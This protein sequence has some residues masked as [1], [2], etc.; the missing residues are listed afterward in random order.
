MHDENPT[1]NDL[2]GRAATAAFFGAPLSGSYAT[3]GILT[4]VE[5]LRLDV[6]GNYPQ[7]TASGTVPVSAT[8]NVHWIA[9]LTSPSP[10]KFTGGI[11]YKDPAVSGF[12][13]TE[14]TVEATSS[15]VP[16]LRWAKV[17]FSGPG[18]SPRKRIFKFKSPYFHKVELEFDSET[19]IL[20]ETALN[21][22]EH[23]NRPATIACENLKIEEVFRR[24]GFDVRTSSAA[25][26]VPTPGAGADTVWS[27]NEMH[28]AMQVY[29]SRFANVAQWSLWTFFARQHEFGSGLGGIMFDDIGPNHRQGTSLFYDSFIS[30]EP[31]GDPNP[32][33]FARRMRFWTAVHEM[34]HSFNLAHSWQKSLGAPYGSPWL[35]LVDEPEA[36]S[37]MNYPYAVV[38]STTA[39]F[40]TFEYRFSDGELLFMRHAPER[41]VQMG[42]EAWFSN[43]GFEDARLHPEPKLKLEVRFNRARPAFEF[44]EPVVAELKLSNISSE[45]QMV[46]ENMLTTL[47]R[48]TILMKRERGA[49]RRYEPYVHMCIQPKARALAPGEAL[50]DSVFLSAGVN[51]LDLA[52]P[53]YYVIQAA[54]H[55]DAGNILSEPVRLRVAPPV[56][57]EEEYLAQDFNSDTV[58]RLLAF[59]GSRVLTSAVDTLREVAA[60]LGERRVA[61]HARVA[62]AMPLAKKA[63]VL[64]LPATIS[65]AITSAA[66]AG[67]KFMTVS[68]KPDEAMETIA[69]AITAKPAQ[70]AETLGHVDYKYYTDYMS[71]SL[72]KAGDERK[73]GDL[74]EQ[75]YE[76]LAARKVKPSVL[77]E[78]KERAASYGPDGKARKAA[79]GSSKSRN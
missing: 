14:V 6:D 78:V 46:D 51:G 30:E 54:L 39:F 22:C 61:V 77:Q 38:G 43:H 66:Q 18:L 17:T 21:T 37:F 44:M 58:G 67:G 79:A 72:A 34:G 31:V 76:T 11:W 71:A 57:R 56:S 62:L 36:R 1:P 12:A 7:M 48:I 19:A 70:A 24:T 2:A 41:F 42:N 25:S 49:T 8:Q 5:E 3:L 74:Q 32:A 28:D 33:A 50:Y 40:D 68:A 63:N 23:P 15:I 60:Q 52:E 45:P 73:A 64:S 16:A 55:T 53:G 10:N 59:D 69:P 29:W 27:N 35:P 4:Q 75:L 26:V 20:A 47:D 9:E 65:T 13:Y